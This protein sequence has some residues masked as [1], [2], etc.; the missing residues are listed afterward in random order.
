MATIAAA[1]STS[2]GIPIKLRVLPE[3]A[4]AM[5]TLEKALFSAPQARDGCIVARHYGFDGR[6]G[7]DFQRTGDEFG[8]TRE[9]VRQIISDSDPLGQ[10][11]PEEGLPTLDRAIAFIAA[12]IPAPAAD[13]E[14]SMSVA[15]LTI[16]LFR[17]EG[18]LNLAGLLG[19]RVAFRIGTWNKTRFVIPAAWPR[20]G[21]FLIRARRDVRRHG[22]ARIADFGSDSL[23][24]AGAQR[25][26][27][28]I[29]TLL[30]SQGDFRWLDRGSGWFWLAATPRNRAVCRVRKMLAV[31]NPLS[32][33]ELRAGLGRMGSPLAP[34]N[35]LLEFCRQIDG[36]SVR[37]DMIYANPG[38]ESAEVLN[39]TEQDIFQLL[40]EN[41]G[42]M[43][44][45]ELISQSC[46]LGIKR[47]T[48][49]QCVTHS[50]IV[51]R[52]DGS[53]YRLIGSQGHLADI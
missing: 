17:I 45:S 19:R 35:T 10:L 51:E 15:G 39:K 12:G 28:L 36:L 7:A 14:K 5:L 33:S 8:L 9:R 49:Y 31:A 42:C 29:E 30:S 43:S 50:P 25:E 38:I 26:A 46:G 32:V 20:L 52:Y 2:C 53:N 23:P 6:G 24:V 4:G 3:L 44:N 41:D 18:I 27:S 48:F 47:P 13:I 34:E 37:G 40:S 22:M 21:D 16:D 11:V 1:L